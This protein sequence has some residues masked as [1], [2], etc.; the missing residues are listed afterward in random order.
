MITVYRLKSC[1]TCRMARKWLA[2]KGMAHRFHDVRS[3]GLKV[4]TLATW[5]DALGWEK[6]LNRRGTTWRNLPYTDKESL[7]PETAL[8]LM[9]AHPALIKR[10][11]FD[12]GGHYAIGFDDSVKALLNGGKA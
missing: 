11:V 6:L 4:A 7:E 9:T 10:P 12:F 1:D 8:A 5:A 3:D 2:E